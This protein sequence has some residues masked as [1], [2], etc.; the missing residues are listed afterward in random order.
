MLIGGNKIVHISGIIIGRLRSLCIINDSA[1]ITDTISLAD[2]GG[3]DC[4][5]HG[6]YLL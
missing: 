6:R 1:T 2:N 4:L 3:L 5:S